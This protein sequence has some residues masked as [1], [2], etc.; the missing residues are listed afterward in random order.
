M[1]R[2]RTDFVIIHCTRTQKDSR[3][4]NKEP[5]GLRWVD[6]KHRKLGVF[7]IGYHFVILR[8]GTC[9]P[10]REVD[11]KGVHLRGYNDNSVGVCLVGGDSGRKGIAGIPEDN[12]PSAQLAQLADLCEALCL[13]YP[14]IKVVGAHDLIEG[15]TDPAF[16][17]KAWLVEPDI[18]KRFKLRESNAK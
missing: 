6:T 17:V 18:R 2:E 14:G 11:T 16:D 12:Y 9:I 8:D 5:I 1:N 4:T 10:G 3:D 13:Y 15:N 7:G